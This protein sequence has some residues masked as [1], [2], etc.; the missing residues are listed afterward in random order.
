M[1]SSI[2]SIAENQ[3]GSELQKYRCSCG[4][5]LFKGK[6]FL[7][8]VE[9]KCKRCG[10]IARFCEVTSSKSEP[11]SFIFSIDTN[12]TILESTHSTENILGHSCSDLVGKSIFEICPK[13]KNILSSEKFSVPTNSDKSYEILQNIFAHKEGKLL[14]AESYFIS[15]YDRQK[16]LGYS[17]FNWIQ[18]R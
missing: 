5:L 7:S 8:M 4:K 2:N 17:I 15:K 9:I 10:I 18:N 11:S 6:L 16:L 12:G 13:L 14:P 1:Y 3:T